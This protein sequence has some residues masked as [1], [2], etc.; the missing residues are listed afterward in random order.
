[1]SVPV[2]IQHDLMSHSTPPKRISREEIRAIY[3][4]GED[5]VV[6][7][8]EALLERIEQ[9]ETRLEALE[10][11]RHKD[12]RNSGKPPS[13]DGFGKRT[14][15]LRGK[16]ERKSGGQKG[17]PGSTLEWS[18]QVDEEV[19]HSVSHCQVCGESLSDV[20]V[21]SLILRQVHELPRLRLVVIEH[22]AEEKRCG[23][24]G[25]LNRAAFPSDVNSVVQYGSGIKGL[26]VYLTV[27][28]L[29]PSLRICELLREVMGLELSEGTLYNACAQCDTSVEPIEEQI[30]QGIQQAEVGHFDETGMRVGGKLMW[31]HVACTEALTYYFIHPKRGQVAM[32]AM[33]A[34]HPNRCART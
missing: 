15:S 18:Q 30:K 1:L 33:A 28:Q 7:L 12:S 29:L 10:N 25:N 21:E 5:A 17:H 2:E 23:C 27:G 34:F 6:M 16:S 20:A 14:K 26:M 32:D 13:G 31:L 3:A 4:Q 9:L 24:C 22:Q 11:Q 8:V 19:R